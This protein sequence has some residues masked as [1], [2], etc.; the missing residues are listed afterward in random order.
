MNYGEAFAKMGIK[1]MG[2]LGASWCALNPEGVM[3]L[4]AHQNYFRL[5]E[6]GIWEYLDPGA[7]NE[8]DHSSSAKISMNLLAEYFEP[9]KQILLIIGKFYTDGGA[10]NGGVIQAA[11]FESAAGGYY[12]AEMVELDRTNGIIRCHCSRR[13]QMR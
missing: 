3:V 9:G 8:I 10:E 1:G 12:V 4:M 6:A 7:P 2:R 11:R 13:E 5:T